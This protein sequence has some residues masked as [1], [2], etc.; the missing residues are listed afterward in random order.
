MS[1]L[2]FCS[3]SMVSL[4]FDA[5]TAT[6]RA[7]LLGGLILKDHIW[8]PLNPRISRSHDFIRQ[9]L[10]TA[11]TV[12]LPGSAHNLAPWQVYGRHLVR[13][14]DLSACMA[15]FCFYSLL[16]AYSSRFLCLRQA[17]LWLSWAIF[18]LADDRIAMRQILCGISG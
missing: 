9:D 6:D 4:S 10:G 11:S 8:V 2:A 15:G 17:G 12:W 13:F 1:H 18:N 14:Y 16:R 7:F 5:G 3:F